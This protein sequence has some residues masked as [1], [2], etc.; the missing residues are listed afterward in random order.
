MSSDKNSWTVY[1]GDGTVRDKMNEPDVKVGDTIHYATNNQQGALTYEVVLK[2]GKKSLKLI[3]SYEMQMAKFDDDDYSGGKKRNKK[4][5][6]K[7]SKSKKS[8]SKKN[9]SKRTKK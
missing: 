1:E 4:T 9:R 2:D 6:S 5:K 3:D 8:K 7:K